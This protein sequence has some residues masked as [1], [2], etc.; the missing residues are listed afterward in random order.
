MIYFHIEIS[1]FIKSIVSFDCM[2]IF[3]MAY[4]CP[5]YSLTWY[6]KPY[7]PS[8]PSARRGSCMATLSFRPT[9]SL[10]LLP[11][12]RRPRIRSSTPTTWCR[13]LAVCASSDFAY[14][15][16]SSSIRSRFATRPSIA[17]GRLN[18]A[19]ILLFT[20]RRIA[21][22]SNCSSTTSSHGGASEYG[23]MLLC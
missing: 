7:P 21:I 22:R 11:L 12:K 6:T 14:Y 20:W 9:S 10:S 23:T 17:G 5:D 15:D 13:R 2:I 3:F 18:S 1:F 16:M 8:A 4:S 19:M